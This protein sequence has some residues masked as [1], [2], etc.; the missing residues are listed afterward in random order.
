MWSLPVK[1][2]EPLMVDWQI[3]YWY[4]EAHAHTALVT[5]VL[6]QNQ[7]GNC[8]VRGT[9][10]PDNELSVKPDPTHVAMPNAEQCLD[11]S[12]LR[13]WAGV[14]CISLKSTTSGLRG[15]ITLVQRPPAI[16]MCRLGLFNA[17]PGGLQLTHLKVP[18]SRHHLPLNDFG[19]SATLPVQF[20]D[21]K[22]I[23]VKI[24]LS[25]KLC[26]YFFIED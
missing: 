19:K 13:T 12:L 8:G 11:Q 22:Y 7:T 21:P 16:G 18:Q 17:S 6:S 3:S 10:A 4:T 15:R 9:R 23:L 24:P 20:S 1:D 26:E 2:R 14:I 5:C 25:E